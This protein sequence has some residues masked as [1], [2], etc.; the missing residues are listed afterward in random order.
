M[1]LRF[2]ENEGIPEHCFTTSFWSLI[3]FSR[4]SNSAFLPAI[5]D[6]KAAEKSRLIFT[7]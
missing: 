1:L 5:R 2:L 3:S 7:E 4:Q 6:Y